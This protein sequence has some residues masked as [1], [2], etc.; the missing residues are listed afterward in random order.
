VV[1]YSHPMAPLPDHLQGVPVGR[2]LLSRDVV[3]E[4][5]RE[6]ILVAATQVF[7]RRG[8]QGTT[9]DNIVAAAGIGVGSFYE[10]FDNKEDCFLRA[11]DRVVA[12]ARAKIT[13]T[14]DPARAWSEQ[15]CAALRTLL[16]LVAAEPDSARIFFVEAQS[17][18]SS[19]EKR[20]LAV[21]DSIVPVLRRGRG[22]N[23]GT[24]DT[25]PPTVEEAIIGG[26]AW[27]LQQR[28]VLGEY[29]DLEGHFDEMAIIVL[30]P[31]L[32]DAGAA[33]AI[34]ASSASL[35]NAV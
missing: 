25:L 14:A 21:I 7:A 17:S 15:I 30:E 10:L 22:L 6:R 4:H 19:A 24:S 12:A 26:L 5:Q 3:V 20:Y 23:K 2:H 27:L 29:N 31:Y 35:P 1:L 8:Y 9:I 32:G 16:A 13:E 34:A 33:A 28:L 11:F 18:G